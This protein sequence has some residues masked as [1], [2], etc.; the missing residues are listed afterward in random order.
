MTILDRVKGKVATFSFYQDGNLWYE[1]DGYEF[2]VPVE[3]AKGGVFNQEEKA[4]H[5]MR[6]IRIHMERAE[7]SRSND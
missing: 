3:D 2:P 7:E 4:I 5:L 6:W 1:V